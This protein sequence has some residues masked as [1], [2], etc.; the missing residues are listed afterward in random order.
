M[1]RDAD[2]SLRMLAGAIYAAM[3]GA[4]SAD[5]A[6]LFSQGFAGAVD[7]NVCVVGGDAALLCEL[8]DRVFFDVDGT[9]GI[10]LF[11]LQICQYVVHALADFISDELDRGAGNIQILRP[12]FKDPGCSFP[13]AIMID[14][15]IA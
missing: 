14:D 9:Q 1:L 8:G 11:G 7:A 4:G 10:A 5:G 13:R 15:R 6:Y 2:D 3:V 12:A